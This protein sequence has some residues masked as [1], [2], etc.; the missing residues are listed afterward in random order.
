MQLGMGTLS[1]EM[2]GSKHVIGRKH[3]G[4]V[5]ISQGNYVGI[6]GLRNME[7]IACSLGR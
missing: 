2:L 4:D 7:L 6:V 3:L 5:I 1:D